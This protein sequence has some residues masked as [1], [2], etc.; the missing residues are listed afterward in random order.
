MRE[1]E[2]SRNVHAG[3]SMGELLFACLSS[4]GWE[5][6]EIL[7]LLFFFFFR[8]TRVSRG[9][10]LVAAVSVAATDGEAGAGSGQ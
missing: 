2:N 6:I 9:R 8:N 7:I 5:F 1:G 3:V 4:P 10:E